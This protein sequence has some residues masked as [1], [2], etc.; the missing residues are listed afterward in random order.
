M[1][2]FSV[3]KLNKMMILSLVA[4]AEE[5]AV[6]A[7]AVVVTKVLVSHVKEVD[8]SAVADWSS[9]TP[10]SLLCER[11]APAHAALSKVNVKCLSHVTHAFRCE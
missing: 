11:V 1:P 10:T 3:S 4:M 8:A 7:V 2:S 5:V 6:A 9:M